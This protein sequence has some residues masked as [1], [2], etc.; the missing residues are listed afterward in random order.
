MRQPRHLASQTI[1]LAVLVAAAIAACVKVGE[2]VLDH[3]TTPFDEPI[4]AWVLARQS[5]LGR[6]FFLVITNVGSPTVLIPLTGAVALWLRG[7]RGLPI[8]GAVVLAP[9]VALALFIALKKAYRRT[10]PHGAERLHQ[11][12]YA[13][14]SGHATSSATVFGVLGYVLWREGCL[15]ASESLVLAT[16][17]TLLIGSSRV[18]LDVHWATDVIGGWSLGALVTGLSAFVYERA[19][20]DTRR[21]GVP[22]R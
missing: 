13:F 15:S 9:T 18:Y 12:T 19:R 22:P 7:R 17:P 10:R 21:W 20:S 1:S 16:A 3:E 5:A 6:R 8:A 11:R 2:D 14:P 4:R